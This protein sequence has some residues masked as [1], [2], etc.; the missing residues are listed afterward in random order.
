MTS[1]LV[2]ESPPAK[3]VVGYCDPWSV[4][5]GE[6]V[7]LHAG[8]HVPVRARLDLVRLG[9]GHHRRFAEEPVPSDLPSHVDLTE[10]PYPAGSYATVEAVLA[11]AIG[12]VTGLGVHFYPSGS[13]GDLVAVDDAVVIRLVDG[14]PQVEMGGSV[15]ATYDRPLE[16]RRWYELAVAVDAERLELVVSPSRLN[17]A[18]RLN[19]A[20]RSGAGG[21]SPT[22]VLEVAAP[23]ELGPAC[24]GTVRLRFAGGGFDGKMAR[25]WMRGSERVE[26]WR[27]PELCLHQLPDPVVTGP[28]WDGTVLDPAARPAHYDAVAFHRDDLY[29][30]GWPVEATVHLP[31]DTPSGIY[32][33]RLRSELGE[34]RVPFFVA[35]GPGA[36]TAD[37]AFLAP[38]ATY[39]AYANH[40]MTITGSD[41]F[42]ARSRLRPEQQYLVDHPEVGLSHYEYHPDG[43]G[44]AFSSRLRPILNT[45]PGADGWGFTP[46]SDI[47][48][49]LARTL[50]AVDVLTDE[51]L[52]HDGAAALEPYRVL[53][54]G[55]HPEYWST[56]MLD[57]LEAWLETGGRLVYLGGNGFYWRV[58]FSDRWP[59]AMEVRRAEDGTRAWTA[60]PGEAHHAFGGEYGGLWRRLGRPPNLVA[61]VGFAAQ[62]FDRAASYRRTPAS[63]DPRA[64]WI[65]EGVEGEVIGDFGVGGGAAGQEVD[66][67]DV[68]LGSPA[69]ALVLAS[70]SEFGEQMLRTKEEF[71]ATVIPARPDPMVRADMVFFETP[72]GGAVF[73]VGSISWWG[74]LAVPTGS[75]G[76]D[77]DVARITANVL[78]RFADPAPF[79]VPG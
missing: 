41:F 51:T 7:R 59:G 20:R 11:T 18:A 78:R 30:A 56:A 23:R 69:H 72:A 65:F 48:A 52:H 13:G 71:H 67:F 63:R 16:Q 2:P 28:A 17:G 46:D 37:V 36:P 62:G 66:R 77:N 50:D 27:M 3:Q 75:G 14:R 57:G 32:C 79:T 25:P 49:Y 42:P 10:R 73:S 35:P 1:P 43:T 29:D 6:G 70:A 5:G 34:D 55:S 45:R 64:A 12:G 53:V 39:L 19:G 4:R 21:G 54:T 61:G 33:F 68:T 74:A 38:V 60:S 24:S 26:R 58:A 22:A 15:A 9:S 47:L 76:G 44:V 40:R 8:S 31:A